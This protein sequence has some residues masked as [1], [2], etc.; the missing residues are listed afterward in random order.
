VI[1]RLSRK[2]A[3]SDEWDAALDHVFGLFVEVEPVGANAGVDGSAVEETFDHLEEGG[4]G[5]EGV[6]EV[7]VEEC[8]SLE[9]VV[10]HHISYIFNAITSL[11][12]NASTQLFY[13]SPQNAIAIIVS[14]EC[15]QACLECVPNGMI[16][17][18]VDMSYLTQSLYDLDGI[19]GASQHGEETHLL[20]LPLINRQNCTALLNSVSALELQFLLLR[21]PADVDGVAYSV[22]ESTAFKLF[23]EETERTHSV[24]SCLSLYIIHQIP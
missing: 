17:Y 20:G 6:S 22:D 7:A 1:R 11:S 18:N 21:V 23:G 13:P 3:T 5:G 16:S 19:A 8:G 2:R 4:S 12:I 10:D 14:F 24:Q 15:L 9:D